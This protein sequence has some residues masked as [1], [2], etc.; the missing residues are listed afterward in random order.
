M[1][2][3]NVTTYLLFETCP[4]YYYLNFVQKYVPICPAIYFIGWFLHSTEFYAH[5]KF[6][7]IFPTLLLYSFVIKVNDILFLFV[8][9]TA[10]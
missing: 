8:S 6:Y 3:I 5:G 1:L 2:S 10:V 7:S 9:W 4:I